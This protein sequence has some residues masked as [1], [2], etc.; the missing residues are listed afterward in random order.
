MG[1]SLRKKEE[2]FQT[3]KKYDQRPQD[4][5]ELIT[6][7]LTDGHWVWNEVSGSQLRS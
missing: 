6:E 5:E 1:I 3:E 7:G 2:G 4:R